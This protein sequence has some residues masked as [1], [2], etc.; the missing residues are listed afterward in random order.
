MGGGGDGGYGERQ[1]KIE[2]DKATA[3]RQLNA[4][5]GVA[6]EAGSTVREQD[7]WRQVSVPIPDGTGKDGGG[8]NQLQMEFDQA[9]YDAAL[10]AEKALAG[11]A[12]KNKAGLEE[13]FGSVRTNAYNAGKTRIDEQK[14]QANRDLK[15]ELFARGLDGGS[16]DVDQNA[17]LGR[18]YA[19]GITDLSGKADAASTQLR[20]DN[21]AARL[22][23]LQSIDSGMDASSALSSAIGQMKV[24]S[25]RAA[26]EAVGTAVGDL[27]TGTGL[28]YNQNRVA[29]GKQNPT[30]LWGSTSATSSRGSSGARSGVVTSAG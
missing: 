16:V 8:G 25:D 14:S 1:D 23:L 4:L 26:A 21:E 2:N 9:A 7:F 3:R 17:L 5:F 11:E 13:L 12:E 29:Q 24:N 28:I 20:G 18:T 6:P 22:Q 19:Q 15:F 30:N 10:A 27:F